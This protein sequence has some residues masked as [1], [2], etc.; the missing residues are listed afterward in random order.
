MAY[1][2]HG[3]SKG[4][5]RAHHKREAARRRKL[6]KSGSQIDPFG[7]ADARGKSKKALRIASVTKGARDGQSPLVPVEDGSE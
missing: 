4:A 6:T 1:R 2:R 7:Y 3:N 5:R